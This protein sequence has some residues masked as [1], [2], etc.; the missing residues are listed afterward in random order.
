MR[1]AAGRISRSSSRRLGASES[2]ALMIPVAFPLGR[3]RFVTR[4]A[5]TGS[6]PVANTIGIVCVA[7]VLSPDWPLQLTFIAWSIG[8]LGIGLL[9]NPTTVGAM[10]YA[11]D[12]REG[13]ISSQIHLA[14]SLGFG[15]MSVV[16]GATVA[17]SDRT[18]LTLQGALGTNFALAALCA[19]TGLVASRGVRNRDPGE[20]DLSVARSIA[21][22]DTI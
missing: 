10:S 7:P 20:S 22:S 2:M 18:A 3:A 9:F 16:G 12:G 6:V 21:A 8:G 13:E 17:L 5:A 14:D 4:P 15:I 1:F 11:V 19:I